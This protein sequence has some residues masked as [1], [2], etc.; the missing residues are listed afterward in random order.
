[1]SAENPVSPKAI[2]ATG[3]AG[4]GAVV[5]TFI[6]WLVGISV[7]NAPSSSDKVADA[8][9]AVP[10]PA[11]ALIA[12]V[13]SAVGAAVSGWKVN[14]PH[15]ITTSELATLQEWRAEAQARAAA[16]GVEEG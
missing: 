16:P 13:I 12:L 9:A 11:S 10:Y 2:A 8:L 4:A 14:D 3:G 15:R 7:W 1:M 5:A 6:T